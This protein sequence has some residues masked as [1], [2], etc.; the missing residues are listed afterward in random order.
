VL[1]IVAM[2]TSIVVPEFDF[3]AALRTPLAERFGQCIARARDLAKSYQK[4]SDFPCVPESGGTEAELVGIES[5]LGRLLP[6]EYRAFLSR[7]RYLKIND[8]LEVGGLDHNGQYVTEQ[9]WISHKHRQGVEY[10]VFANYW[11][12]ADGDQLMFDMSDPDFPVVAYLHEH[13]PLYET[14]APSFS[15]ALWRL[16]DEGDEQDEPG[17]GEDEPGEDGQDE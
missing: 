17:D 15:L 8:G 16:V 5:R 4:F 14:F 11:A 3:S 10:L 7:C 12:Y 13:G 9:P 2:H 1:E 6:P